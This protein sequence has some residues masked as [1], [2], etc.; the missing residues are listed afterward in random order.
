SRRVCIHT[1]EMGAWYGGSGISASASW[2]SACTK[3]SG[4]SMTAISTSVPRIISGLPTL[5]LATLRP[6]PGAASTPIIR[7]WFARFKPSSIAT[8]LPVTLGVL[9]TRRFPA[10]NHREEDMAKGK[11]RSTS[12]GLEVP[13]PVVRSLQ[14][15]AV[16]PSTG[17]N[18]YNETVVHVPWEPLLP[19]PTGRKIAVIDYD[20]ANKCYYSPVNLEDPRLLANNGFDPSEADPRFHQQ[21]VYAIASRTIH[22]F[23]VA[24]GREIHWRRAD[25][26]GGSGEHG[27]ATRKTNDIWV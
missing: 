5:H 14:V 4:S 22:M 12:S 6:P 26:F 9:L 2:I 17:K 18:A 10:A 1:V 7:R 27:N 15:Y 23:E 25:R 8:G 13:T 3:R 16:D 19:G 24:L 21:M 11:M 20:A